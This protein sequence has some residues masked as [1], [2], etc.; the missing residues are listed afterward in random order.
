MK[1]V[2][3]LNFTI[4]SALLIFSRAAWEKL[5]EKIPMH[6]SLSGKPD[7]WG[8]KSF[9]TWFLLPL[10]TIGFNIFMYGISILIKKYP[11]LLNIPNKD[12]FLKLS[13]NKKEPIL[14][15]I[16]EMFYWICLPFNCLMLSICIGDYQVAIGT[17]N[18]L[19]WHFIITIFL[20]IISYFIIIPIFYNKI[21]YEIRKALNYFNS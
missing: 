2:N 18:D 1:T 5:P 3:V 10:I 21:N 7:S 6:Y 15:L 17:R 14:K 9:L 12:A 16:K 4:L 19:K 11:K 13:P 20:F 8:N